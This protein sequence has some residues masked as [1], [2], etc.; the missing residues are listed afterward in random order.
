M[1][2]MYWCVYVLVGRESEAGERL[3]RGSGRATILKPTVNIS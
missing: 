2:G 3:E 1:M